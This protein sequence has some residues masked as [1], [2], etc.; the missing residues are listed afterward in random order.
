[1]FSII[2]LF[3][4]LFSDMKIKER[5]VI[6]PNKRRLMKVEHFKKLWIPQNRKILVSEC[7]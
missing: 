6:G 7:H 3:F 1:M 5:E 4:H 2:E